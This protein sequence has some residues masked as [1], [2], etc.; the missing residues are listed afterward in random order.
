MKSIVHI[1]SGES[2]AGCLRHGLREGDVIGHEIFSVRDDLS[3]GPL[4]NLKERLHF[5]VHE[6]AGDP[7][8]TKLQKNLVAGAESWPS[9]DAFTGREIVIWHSPNVIEQMTLRMV[10]S[11]LDGCE[12]L[13]IETNRP[14]S[15][16]RATAEHT[17]DSLFAMN[18][19]GTRLSANRIEALRADWERLRES[20][21]LLRILTSG[22]IAP[23][24][25]CYYDAQ[26]LG[27]CTSTPKLAARVIGEVLGTCGQVVSDTFIAYRVRKLVEKRLLI[28]GG[29]LGSRYDFTVQ[30]A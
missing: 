21:E 11:R 13:E 20:P 27:Q 24:D 8:D 5:L 7:S 10:V 1:V 6:V 26:I 28:A 4:R 22:R 30:L 15:P 18:N 2:A 16:K 29:T 23:V 19:T 12:L 17:P 9:R 3:I 25:M 14:G